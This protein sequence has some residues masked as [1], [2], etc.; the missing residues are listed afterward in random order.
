MHFEIKQ[1]PLCSAIRLAQFFCGANLMSDNPRI[2]V[3]GTGAIGG[4]YG[5]MLVRAGFDVHFL[6]RTD[7]RIVA[8]SGL[9]I[10]SQVFGDLGAEKVNAYWR[11]EDMPQCDWLLVG[12]K[13][14]GNDSLAPLLAR[15]SAPNGKILILQNGLGIEDR[16][17]PL[18]PDVLHLLGGVCMVGAYRTA[19]GQVEHLALGDIQLGYHSGPI[20]DAGEKHAIALSCAE[21][22]IKAG[23]KANVSD[24]L[25]RARWQKLLWNTPFNGMSVL[26][27]KGTREL[28]EDPD[29]RELIQ[30]IIHEVFTAAT[31]C[32]HPLPADLPEKVIALTEMMPNYLPSMY[33]DFEQRRPME[34]EAI[35][36]APLAAARRVGFEM[37]ATEALYQSLRLMEAQ[38][39]KKTA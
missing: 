17:R 8:E 10:R 30:S 20:A 13:S 34:L 33:L 1:T 25:A 27:G 12:T 22:F 5:V 31:L 18:L 35:Y 28:V 11:V 36:E 32:G 6:L 24:D 26:L 39:Q 14:T 7:Y 15:A 21:L 19:P 9:I 38:N 2:G 37:R 4:F 3:I 23:I 16:L 29:S